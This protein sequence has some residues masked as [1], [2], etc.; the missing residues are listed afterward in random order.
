MNDRKTILEN[1]IECVCKSRENE[2][3]TPENNFELIGLFWGLYLKDK[4]PD[5]L[6]QFAR[7]GISAEDVAIMMALLKIAR[8]TKGNFKED[9]YIDCCGYIACAGELGGKN[10]D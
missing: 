9:S 2:Y 10:N 4:Y 6:S 8:I 1:A 7:N 3:G 5:K